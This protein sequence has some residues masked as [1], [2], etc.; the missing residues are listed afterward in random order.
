LTN[1]DRIG[2]DTF[3]GAYASDYLRRKGAGRWDIRRAVIRASK[4]AALTITRMGAQ[5]G[6][7]WA[8]EIDRF[9]APFNEPDIAE[10]TVSDDG[11][12]L[13]SM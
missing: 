13:V 5:T 3:T 10:R 6:I 9:H 7:P 11:G 2:S 12:N 1:T 4:A 8:D